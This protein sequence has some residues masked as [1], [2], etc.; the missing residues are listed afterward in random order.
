MFT[1]LIA[2]IPPNYLDPVSGGALLQILLAILLGIS[3][4]I[5][6]FWRQINTTITKIREKFNK[7]E[8][9]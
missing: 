6:A 3:L 4:F 2:F 9:P 7:R 8:E 1:T 5:R